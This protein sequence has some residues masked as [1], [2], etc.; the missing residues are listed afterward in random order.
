MISLRGCDGSLLVHALFMHFGVL[1]FRFNF[2]VRNFKEYV[3]DKL[4]NA[5]MIVTLRFLDCCTTAP[6][7]PN[8]ISSISPIGFVW[9]CSLREDPLPNNILTTRRNCTG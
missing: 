8:M 6:S 7:E 2:R 3:C 9:A 5:D 1:C 4:A